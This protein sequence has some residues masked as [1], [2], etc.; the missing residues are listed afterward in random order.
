[1]LEVLACRRRRS[2]GGLFQLEV[3]AKQ[4]IHL[5][6]PTNHGGD[7][8]PEPGGRKPHLADGPGWS[9]PGSQARGM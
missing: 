6:Q 7:V 8:L 4:I 2:A 5:R 1:M 3:Q 9:A